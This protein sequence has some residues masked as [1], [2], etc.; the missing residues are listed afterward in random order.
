MNMH[1]DRS[2]SFMRSPRTRW[3]ILTALALLLAIFINLLVSLLP[4]SVTRFDM[5]STKL[6]DLSD[7]SEEYIRSLDEEV[8]IHYICITG[9]EDEG[10]RTL[11][12]RYD[13]LSDKLTVNEVDPAVHPTFISRY[14]DRELSDNSIIVESAKRSKVLEY[15]DLLLY[16]VYATDDG[17]QYTPIGEMIHA[18]FST[19]YNTY[20]DLFDYGTYS[21]DIAFTGEGTI[22]SAIDYAIGDI[23]PKV[24]TVTGHGETEL[25]S[26]LL[27]YLALDNI[28]TSELALPTAE[29]LPEDANCLVINAPQ[30]DLTEAEASLLREYLIGG[31]NI[32]LLTDSSATA[33]TNLMNL[34]QEFGLEGSAGILR[35]N[36][37]DR[38]YSY[39]Y[40]LL[41][42]SDGAR[43]LFDLNAYTLLMP[44]AHPISMTE[45][46]YPMTYTSLFRTSQKAILEPIEEEG[47][48]GTASEDDVQTDST[49][50]LEAA[51]YDVGALVKLQTEQGS[52]KICW[53]GSSVMLNSDYNSF[54]SGGNYTY[55][56]AIIESMCE[57]TNSIV[58]D[59]KQMAE[60][61]VVLSVGQASFWA[62][63]IIALIPLSI[64]VTGIIIRERRRRR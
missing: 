55:F 37:S 16:T 44:Y 32:M 10:V 41:P 11:L 14:T 36:D 26:A 25:S 46:E 8:T 59:S 30:I 2:K 7:F 45:C 57:K 56:L 40:F 64:V 58:I 39:P 9:N 48:E 29:A 22:T 12:S 15:T 42:F 6:T 28:D 1:F 47:E 3:L 27:S 21:Y 23:L 20:K 53:I 63:I 34:M 33:L 4:S 51:S 38:Y 54:V 49:E 24:Y 18:D 13:E 5:T 61:S 31:G 50:A 19:Y 60:P 43:D 17:S 62:V 35:E 52:G